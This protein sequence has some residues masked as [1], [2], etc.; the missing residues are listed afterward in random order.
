MQELGNPKD[1]VSFRTATRQWFE[2]ID[3]DLSGEIDKEE[4]KAEFKRLQQ[5]EQHAEFFPTHFDGNKNSSLIVD[6]FEAALIHSVGT[7]IPGLGAMN[8]I[9]LWSLF[10][11][12]D[13]NGDGMLV[14]MLT[15][16]SH[17]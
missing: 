2:R 3:N 4:I 1:G 10:L 5:T 12:V 16:M 15:S 6:E 17:I 14:S 13:E 11:R 7:S 8:V 9:T